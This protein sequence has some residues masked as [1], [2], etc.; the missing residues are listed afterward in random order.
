MLATLSSGVA[1]GTEYAHFS[2]TSDI[3]IIAM[4]DCM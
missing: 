1:G 3:T 4:H 2:S